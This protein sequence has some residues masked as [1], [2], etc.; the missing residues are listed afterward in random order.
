MQHKVKI[1]EHVHGSKCVKIYYIFYFAF[2]K[3]LQPVSSTR[4]KS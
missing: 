4:D 3:L 1:P 2:I